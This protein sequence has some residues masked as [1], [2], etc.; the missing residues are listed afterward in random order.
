VFFANFAG[1]VPH[2]RATPTPETNARVSVPA[3][4]KC[5]LRFLPFL[6][7]ERNVTGKK[8]GD[9]LIFYLPTIE[10]GAVAWLV[11]AP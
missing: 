7:E 5:T 9:R 2:E 10:R 8:V 6:G 3:R 1:L 4:R 11:D